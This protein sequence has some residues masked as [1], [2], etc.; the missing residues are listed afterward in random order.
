[1]LEYYLSQVTPVSS[2]RMYVNARYHKCRAR[3]NP[4]SICILVQ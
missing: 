4:V 1:M 2:P 3:C